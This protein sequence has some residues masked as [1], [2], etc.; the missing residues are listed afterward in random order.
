MTLGLDITTL[1]PNTGQLTTEDR[2]DALAYALAACT[3]GG[4]VTTLEA[5]WVTGKWRLRRPSYVYAAARMC[6]A[7]RAELAASAAGRPGAFPVSQS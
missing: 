1:S 6:E 5:E 3:S 7:R 2:L 4:E